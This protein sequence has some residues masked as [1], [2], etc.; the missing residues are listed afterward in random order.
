MSCRL[1]VAAALFTGLLAREAQEAPADGPDATFLQLDDCLRAALLRS[2][3]GQRVDEVTHV[4]LSE[5][6]Q[7]VDLLL[8]LGDAELRDLRHAA[9]LTIG[10]A[11]KLIATAQA[12]G[13]SGSVSL[14]LQSQRAPA[15]RSLRAET[16]EAAA[17]A[18]VAGLSLAERHMALHAYLLE[19]YSFEVT[20]DNA[21]VSLSINFLKITD[22]NLQTSVLTL[23]AWVRQQWRDERLAFNSTLWNIEFTRFHAEPLS[24]ENSRIWTPDIELYNGQASLKSSLTSQLASVYPDGSVFWSRPGSLQVLCKFKGLRNFPL[25]ELSCVLEFGAWILDKSAQDIQKRQLDGGFNFPGKGD[26]AGTSL[27]AGSTYQDYYINDVSAYRLEK[28]Y[29]CCP[30]PFPQVMY[31]LVIHR[32]NTFYVMKLILPQISMA[33]LST[34]TYFMN[35][36]IG[37]RLGFGI[38]L[39]LAVIATDIV[40][41]EFMP[42]CNEVLLMNWISWLSLI[43]CLIAIF[44]SGLVLSMYH[45]DVANFEQVL[46]FWARHVCHRMMGAFRY[47]RSRCLSTSTRNEIRSLQVQDPPESSDSSDSLETSPRPP[48]Q[49]LCQSQAD[50]ARAE[51]GSVPGSLEQ[52]ELPAAETPDS[53]RSPTM[54]A[55]NSGVSMA[56]LLRSMPSFSEHTP[57]QRRTL[58]GMLRRMT[59]NGAKKAQESKTEQRLRMEMYRE[60]FYILDDDY[61]GE[62]DSRQVNNFGQFMLGKDWSQEH[63]EE[64]MDTCDIDKDGGLSFEEFANFC[65]ISIFAST[66]AKEMA[67]FSE[68][69]KLFISVANTR[70]MFLKRKWQTRS[71]TVDYVF[72]WLAPL[73]GSLAMI[74]LL[75]TDFEPDDE[76]IEFL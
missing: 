44:E 2:L 72:R 53:P 33:A 57:H 12:S 5:G 16:S 42:V 52:E 66:E 76:L 69:M 60:A 18:A 49:E 40:A 62:L 34:I 64:F 29:D 14:P 36:N 65:E 71:K 45:L 63:L 11:H 39:V 25:D 46:P 22:L 9:K 61:S 35:A 10:Q 28:S 67:Y 19:R 4:L 31:K 75:S 59:T 47:A 8:S 1:V 17:A 27:T 3:S 50:A 58:R 13:C 6:I 70:E 7:T 26:E 15:P 24:L 41:T 55:L 23:P 68:M 54:R 48:D 21:S 32:A 73:C 20:P 56:S 37:E 74:I 30:H 51:P 43:M 38:T